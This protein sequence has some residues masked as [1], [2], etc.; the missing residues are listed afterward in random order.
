MDL[1]PGFRKANNIDVQ[2]KNTQISCVYRKWKE[3][4]EV[5][6][7]FNSKRETKYIQICGG[8]GIGKTTFI[9]ELGRICIQRGLFQSGIYI[10]NGK[11]V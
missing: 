7:E 2:F 1:S 11:D 6:K 10:V 3:I 5:F 4:T 9:Q 8:N